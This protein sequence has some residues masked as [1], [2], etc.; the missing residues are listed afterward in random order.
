MK[1]FVQLKTPT[2]QREQNLEGEPTETNGQQGVERKEVTLE[3]RELPFF[4]KYLVKFVKKS[5]ISTN[6]RDTRTLHLK[7]NLSL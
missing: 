5:T 1:E 4:L 3:Q 7:K 6:V 2:C